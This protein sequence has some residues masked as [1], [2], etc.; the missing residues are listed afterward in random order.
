MLKHARTAGTVAALGAVLVLSGCGSDGDAKGADGG[1]GAG[2]APT[3]GAAQSPGGGGGLANGNWVAKT[4][5][6]TFVLSV[7]NGQASLIGS[8]T[9]AGKVTGDGAPKLELR[10][11]AGKTERANGTVAQEDGGKTLKVTW[12]GGLVDTFRQV[13]EGA[14]S[15][16][17]PSG[18][19]S[20][21]PSGFP[22]ELPSGFPSVLPSGM[23]SA[24]PARPAS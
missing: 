2:G 23:P 10:C 13:P 7:S 16:G 12:G 19:P 21:L 14:A 11:S 1:R 18:M 9:C 5:G 8:Y 20:N 3:P 17:L 24:L 6:G 22:S 15:G 4:A